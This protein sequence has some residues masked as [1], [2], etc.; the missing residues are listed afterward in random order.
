MFNT[1]KTMAE[2]IDIATIAN[3]PAEASVDGR[4]AKSHALKD[5][6]EADRYVASKNNS[7]KRGLG[8][9]RQRTAPPGAV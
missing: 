2:E 6:I 4:S 8:I 5:L 3:K 7:R 9:I 1:V